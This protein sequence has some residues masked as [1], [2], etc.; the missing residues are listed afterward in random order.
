M[1]KQQLLAG[2]EKAALLLAAFLLQLAVSAAVGSP[3]VAPP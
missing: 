1:K 2:K 3:N